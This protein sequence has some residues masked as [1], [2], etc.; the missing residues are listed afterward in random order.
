L[1][2]INSKND[3]KNVHWAGSELD[4]R[5]FVVSRINWNSKAD[6]MRLIRDTLNLKV[7]DFVFVD[8]RADQ[9]EMVTA[10]VPEVPR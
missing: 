10:S 6:N 5:D 9:R 8:D 7:K 2:A 3:P 4:E 1:L